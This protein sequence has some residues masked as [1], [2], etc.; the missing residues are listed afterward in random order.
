MVDWQAVESNIACGKIDIQNFGMNENEHIVRQNDLFIASLLVQLCLAFGDWLQFSS[1]MML[2]F[3]M[4]YMKDKTSSNY[5]SSIFT[6]TQKRQWNKS[7]IL[8]A[9]SRTRKKNYKL[10]TVRC[11]SNRINA[12][13]MQTSQLPNCRNIS[14]KRKHADFISNCVLKFHAM[15][16]TW[17]LAHHIITRSKYLPIIR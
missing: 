1:Y 5:D 9:S 7:H 2:H 12:A 6:R 13:K 17:D 11:L 16:I 14:L 8:S 3:M 15:P 4:L 10:V